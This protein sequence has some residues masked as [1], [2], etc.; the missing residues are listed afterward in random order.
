MHLTG[1]NAIET[2]EQSVNSTSVN[3]LHA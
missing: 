1:E 3:S 2:G